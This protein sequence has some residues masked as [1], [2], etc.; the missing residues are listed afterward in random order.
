MAFREALAAVRI[1]LEVGIGFEEEDLLNSALKSVISTQFDC[2]SYCI[3]YRSL[4]HNKLFKDHPELVR[5][6]G[7]HTLVLQL[8]D[9]YL[10]IDQT[11]SHDRHNARKLK[12]LARHVRDSVCCVSLCCFNEVL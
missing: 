12:S 4:S 1:R 10:G 11:A 3:L 9:V 2:S 6:L 5:S 8:L 7:V